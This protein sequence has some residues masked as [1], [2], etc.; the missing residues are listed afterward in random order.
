M[1]EI[2][3]LSTVT[4]SSLLRSPF[5]HRRSILGVPSFLLNRTSFKSELIEEKTE[6]EQFIT[7]TERCEGGGTRLNRCEQERQLSNSVIEDQSV[8]EKHRQIERFVRGEVE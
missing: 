4:H 5:R 2:S 1:E 8:A 3:L 6:T 7:E